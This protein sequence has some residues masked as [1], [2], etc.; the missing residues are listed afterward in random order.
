M[1]YHDC[2]LLVVDVQNDFCSGGTLA[3]PDGEA[4]VPVVNR[5]CAR[6]GPALGARVLTQDWHPAAHRSFASGHEGRAAFEST[7]MPYG[8]Q[9]LWP[10]HCVQGTS[11]ADFHPALD[12]TG[13]ELILRKGF[14]AHVDSYSA[15]YENDHRTATGL[16]GYLRERGIRRL[17]LVGL[18][19]DFCVSYS[20]IDGAREGFDVAV[21]EDGCRGIDL[22]GSLDRAW[23]EMTAA[24]VGRVGSASL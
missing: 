4:V 13:A 23:E 12:V 5:L 6:L 24:G 10:A 1:T 18:A 22:D 19:T 9:V 20:A 7:T 3:V 2:A 17:L 16:A 8:E 14:R 21:V 11:G 15:F